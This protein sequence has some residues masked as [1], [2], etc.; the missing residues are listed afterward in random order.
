MFS[1]ESHHDLLRAAR[2]SDYSYGKFYHCDF[3]AISFISTWRR[4]ASK[5]RFD[6]WKIVTWSCC[7]VRICVLQNENYTSVDSIQRRVAR[8]FKSFEYLI[9]CMLLS[10]IDFN[11]I[12]KQSTICLLY[13]NFSNIPEENISKFGKSVSL[14]TI[15]ASNGSRVMT[16]LRSRFENHSV[17]ECNQLRERFRRDFPLRSM[18]C[19]P[20]FSAFHRVPSIFSEI[21]KIVEKCLVRCVCGIFTKL[22][23]EMHGFA[24][25][26]SSWYY[27]KLKSWYLRYIRFRS[28]IK[29]V[30][31][32]HEQ[33]WIN[34]PRCNSRK[35]RLQLE[36]FVS[37]KSFATPR[38][39][40]N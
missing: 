25:R 16:K 19:I 7:S 1:C 20:L 10:S 13:L 8:T 26:D 6:K 29:E 34:Y 4:I 11:V 31:N 24:G 15:F 21:C 39:W 17:S 18:T 9:K 28:R 3:S 12:K 33:P 36:S 30:A 32:S 35:P 5:R 14:E 38:T 37:L 22:A 40:I 2:S 27:Y 23:W